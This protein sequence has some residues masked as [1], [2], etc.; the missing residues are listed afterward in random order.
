MKYH[1]PVLPLDKSI[2]PVSALGAVVV[3]AESTK[4]EV[5]QIAL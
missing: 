4:Q 3:A 2:F 5:R 1:P